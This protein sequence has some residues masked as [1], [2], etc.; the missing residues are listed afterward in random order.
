MIRTQPLE[1]SNFSGGIT[2]T[3]IDADPSKC[4]IADNL[5][6]TENG[7]L[8]TRPGCKVL[9]GPDV[10]VTVGRIINLLDED[11]RMILHNQSSLFNNNPN[12]ASEIL[13]P[14]GNGAFPNSGK[15]ISY[16]VWNDQTYMVPNG[17]PNSSSLVTK[18]FY[19]APSTLKMI[20]SGLP[21]ISAFGITSTAGAFNY[22][23]AVHYEYTYT[24]ASKTYQ[25]LGVVT[26]VEAPLVQAPNI[27]SITLTGL[28]ALS[29]GSTKN[30]D[31]AVIKK[32]I[33][34]TVAGGTVF[35]KIGEISNAT[36]SFVDN[37][38]DSVIQNNEILYSTGTGIDNAPPPPC[39]FLHITGD[40]AFYA[41]IFESG[42]LLKTRVRQ[43]IIGDPDSSPPSFY[44]DVGRDIVG[45]SSVNGDPIIITTRGVYRV[46]GRFDD[47]GQGGM[48]TRRIDD[49]ASTVSNNSIVQIPGGIVWLDSTAVYLSDGFNVEKIS[50]GLDDTISSLATQY[51]TSFPTQ[52]VYDSK[53]RLV[54]WTC[55]FT[56]GTRARRILVL[57][58]K[59][60][61]KPS[62]V[63]TTWSGKTDFT[64]ESLAL[65]SGNLVRSDQY[66]YIHRYS[67]TEYSDR[68]VDTG[69]ATEETWAK[70]PII[71]NFVSSAV[72]F[73]G[74]FTRK[75]VPRVTLTF[76]K[77]TNANIQ[78]RSINDDTNEASDLA[79]IEFRDDITWGDE[80]IT[81][82]DETITWNFDGIFEAQ[83]RFPAGDLRC[84]YKQIQITNASSI[85]KNSDSLGLVTLNN[86]SNTA[87]LNDY[88]GMDPDTVEWPK[89]SIGLELYFDFDNYTRA[90]VVTARTAA[91]L[92]FSDPL[93]LIPD[94]VSKFIL[95]GI[96]VD[97][98]INL[99]GVTLHWAPLSKT[100]EMF[101]GVKGSNV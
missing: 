45:L 29:N 78:T 64:A 5:L 18:L 86:V 4:E 1:I 28:V 84:S 75:W 96:D 3:Y 97:Q 19:S 15:T 50:L 27:S 56:S 49:T 20:T 67:D 76:D 88:N 95:K 92:T 14:S 68:V 57:D 71:W 81:W 42:S 69:N 40:T 32:F 58:L 25:D 94:G 30:Y 91:T 72:N 10:E 36:T 47:F 60:G 9:N 16:G 37:F 8:I 26:Y 66:G 100:Q 38:S 33:Y 82:G 13:G 51:S 62:S 54:Y 80:I 43:S 52:G 90:Y 41:Y 77:V 98:A 101:S 7:K 35:Y 87:T 85:I 61:T 17:E 21:A 23:Y 6:I 46:D 55:G 11:T 12:L 99:L 22:V 89:E 65:F 34:R 63:F 31:T 93:G 74:K 59:W 44:V 70:D 73:D 83:R 39:K 2:D 24:V 48:V 79:V 53:R